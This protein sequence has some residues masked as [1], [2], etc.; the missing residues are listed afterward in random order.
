MGYQNLCAKLRENKEYQACGSKDACVVDK[1]K[2]HHKCSA[3]KNMT[4]S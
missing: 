3:K 4:H 1:K 2:T